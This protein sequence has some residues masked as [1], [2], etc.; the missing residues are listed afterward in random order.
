MILNT[1]CLL[2]QGVRG[3]AWRLL[4]TCIRSAY[5]LNLH[6]ID[7]GKPRGH[8]QPS[9]VE[10]WCIEEEWRRA[11]WAIWEMDVFASVIRRCPAGID[12]SQN[13]TFLPVEDEQWYRGEPQPSCPLELNGAERWKTLV[14]A[15]T[16]SPRAWFI[17]IN[18][19]MKDAQNIS[20]PMNIEKPMIP[21]SR[22]KEDNIIPT[23]SHR[24]HTRKQTPAVSRLNIVLN[25]LYCTVMA[26]P[27]E[28]RYYGQYLD[29]SG[30]DIKHQGAI[31]QRQIHS[32]VYGIY[33]MIQLTKLMVLKYH[34]FRAG[35]S[36]TSQRNLGSENSPDAGSTNIATSE[37]SYIETTESPHL[38]QYFEAS[39]NVVRIT[40]SCSEDFYTHVNPFTASTTWL[41]GAV[42]LLHRSLLP[43]E[44]S[45]RDLIKSNFD[46]LCLT[47]QKTIEFWSMS[48]VPL[49]H[50]ETLE[51][52]LEK[53]RDNPSG[54][55]RYQYERPF[56][57]TGGTT[58]HQPQ[59]KRTSPQAAPQNTASE[60]SNVDEIFKYLSADNGT[61]DKPALKTLLPRQTS[62]SGMQG[63]QD[64]SYLSSLGN[65]YTP[66]P[67]VLGNAQNQQPYSMASSEQ[68]PGTEQLRSV[69]S[70]EAEAHFSSCFLD[71]GQFALERN[72]DMDF[73]NY[74]D[75][76][77]SGS[78]MP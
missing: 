25:S 15:K 66:R 41:A 7:A 47:Y 73:S 23:K 45:N 31:A 59:S 11:W 46:L 17:I 32:H 42:Q 29:F 6:L 40:R 56:V 78:Y 58:G 35:M 12:W 36:W 26:L 24:E 68:V 10:Q 53:M 50:W 55:E 77:F 39:E 18:S 1:L 37:A 20:S 60:F 49:K 14:A 22:H 27:R 43:E 16:Q 57:F 38:A 64:F 9:S 71:S 21:D 44:C 3:R 2:V 8:Y 70:A 75:E 74:L 34:V 33:M 28:L 65:I 54:E 63:Q 76:V 62:L 61:S 19:L 67:P 51:N 48:R 72:V 13:E 30:C 52:G 69:S 4:G 5:E